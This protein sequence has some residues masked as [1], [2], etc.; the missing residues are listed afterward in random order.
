MCLGNERFVGISCYLGFLIDFGDTTYTLFRQGQWA[1]EDHRSSRVYKGTNG[2]EAY[3]FSGCDDGQTSADTSVHF[4][5]GLLSGDGVI[6]YRNELKNE[7]FT[8]PFGTAKS[9]GSSCFEI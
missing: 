5:S 7:N 9:E 4:L 2:G 1:W 3:S 8:L 6:Y